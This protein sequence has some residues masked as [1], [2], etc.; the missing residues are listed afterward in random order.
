MLLQ[1]A[2]EDRHLLLQGL[3][4]FRLLLQ[5]PE[6]SREVMDLG[7]HRVDLRSLPAHVAARC[8]DVLACARP[9]GRG[10]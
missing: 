2:R 8:R 9:R 7:G 10:G 1:K 6:L 3:H 5:A 4:A